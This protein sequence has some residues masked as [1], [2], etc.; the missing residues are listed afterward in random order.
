M[1]GDVQMLPTAK[2]L[3]FRTTLDCECL[4]SPRRFRSICDAC[5]QSEWNG[6][7]CESYLFYLF[8]KR[9]SVLPPSVHNRL[10]FLNQVNLVVPDWETAAS[11]FR[12]SNRESTSVGCR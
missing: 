1:T 6:P 8:Q 4:R 3:I 12:R 9:S 11:S 2:L 10:I 5:K 7:L